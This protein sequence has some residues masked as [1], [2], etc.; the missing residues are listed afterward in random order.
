MVCLCSP[1]SGLQRRLG[2]SQIHSSK[3]STFSRLIGSVACLHLCKFLSSTNRS[4]KSSSSSPVSTA[5][6]LVARSRR[7]RDSFG[8]LRERDA[9]RNLDGVG[10]ETG[11]RKSSAAP[12]SGPQGGSGTGRRLPAEI[13]EVSMESG[14]YR[15][16]VAATSVR[17][18]KEK[19]GSLRTNA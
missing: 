18:R 7:R 8:E 9:G 13:G 12:R 4:I 15:G 2:S 5:S 19:K 16:D 14:G 10:R 6:S 17:I 11:N 1:S 3:T